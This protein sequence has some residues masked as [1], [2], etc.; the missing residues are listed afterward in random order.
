M[1]K[2]I[3]TPQVPTVP[4]K[5]EKLNRPVFGLKERYCG[6]LRLPETKQIE[7]VAN[8]NNILVETNTLSYRCGGSD[9]I[10]C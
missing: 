5:R 9:G 1:R 6:C 10:A 8:A 4:T 3:H 7:S 2:H